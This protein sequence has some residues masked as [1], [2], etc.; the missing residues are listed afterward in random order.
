MDTKVRKTLLLLEVLFAALMSLPWLVPHVGFLALVGFVPLLLMDRIATLAGVRHFWVWHY[1][2]FVLWNTF[3]TFWVCNATVGGGVFAILANALQMSLVFGLFRFSKRYLRG[4]LPYVFL[5][6][7]WIAWERAY[8]GAQI[9]WPW[10][11]L[12]NAFASSTRLIQWYEFTGTLGGSLWIWTC[13]LSVFGIL[14]ALLDGRWPIYTR[15]ARW[16]ALFVLVTVFFAP[17]MLSF[18]IWKNYSE[19]SEGKLDVLI[20]Q[21]NFDPYQKFQSLSQQQQTAILLSQY[22][23]ELDDRS[24]SSVS[25]LLLLAP[26]TFCGDVTCGEYSSGGTWNRFH[27]FLSDYENV[28][29]IFGASTYEYF[30]SDTS[31]SP[32]ARRLM[33]GVWYESHN[34][35]L[36]LDKQGN[37]EIYHKS[38]LV[39]GVEMTPY[40][41]VIGPI[42]KWIDAPIGHCVGQDEVSLLHA[43]DVPLGCAI[44]YESIYGEFC[45]EYV[46]KGA[47]ALT[48]ITN[49]A[50]WGD[51]PGYRQH[52]SY[53]RLRAIELR[54][55]IAR[56]GN[57]GI[58]AFVDQR[59]EVVQRGPWWE[60]AT[61]RGSMNL[62]SFETVFV[63]YG[64]ICGRVCTFLFIMLLLCIIVRVVTGRTAHEV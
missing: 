19:V 61:L 23:E 3:T 45:A 34:S 25:H 16:A 32:N 13:N 53:S 43:G 7:M 15:K 2:A 6:V 28:S 12:G 26:E 48:V 46:R 47:Q 38:K 17:M 30:S 41:K 5:A 62:N 52:F 51:T 31:P 9:S 36:S 35:A 60:M 29:I 42:A 11:V 58:S 57:T 59:G 63:H 56:C 37:T 22:A 54:R 21:P 50:W 10:L 33:D 49:D 55:D 40:P 14:S 20:A 44:C 27:S 39:V 1:L 64:D 24:D 18:V 8:F 4:A